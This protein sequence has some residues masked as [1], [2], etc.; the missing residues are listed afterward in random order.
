MVNVRHLILDILAC[1][2]TPEKRLRSRRFRVKDK[3]A[4]LFKNAQVVQGTCSSLDPPESTNTR[5][6][7]ANLNGL[8]H[9]R[10][11]WHTSHQAKALLTNTPSRLRPGP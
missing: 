6:Q 11:R 10:V 9:G 1:S 5:V 8:D 7:H 4:P 2:L 3:R